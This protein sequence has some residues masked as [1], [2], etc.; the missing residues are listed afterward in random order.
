VRKGALVDKGGPRP[1]SAAGSG[2]TEKRKSEKEGLFSGK[3]GDQ[4]GERGERGFQ[5]QKY[6]KNRPHP[7]EE[8]RKRGCSVARVTE[9]LTKEGTWTE[10]GEL[11][12]AHEPYSFS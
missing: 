10:K 2:G 1:A 4:S 9:E 12:K 11:K 8:G 7:A 6:R 5:M 3:C